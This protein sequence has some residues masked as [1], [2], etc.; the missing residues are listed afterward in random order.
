[1]QPDENDVSTSEIFGYAVYAVP[2][3]ALSS[4]IV[5]LVPPFYSEV[6]G[7]PLAAVGSVFMFLRIMDAV[8]DPAM[9]WLLDRHLFKQAHKPW[10]LAA[11]P[12]AM[13]SGVLL[14]FPPPGL[15]SA[16]Y[17]FGAGFIAYSAYTI[18]LVTHQAW[19]AALARTPRSLS[20]LFGFRELAVIAGVLGTFSLPAIAEAMGYPELETKVHVAGIY[21]VCCFAVCT[22]LSLWMSSDPPSPT[23]RQTS[24]FA[25]ARQILARRD[26]ILLSLAYLASNFGLMSISVLTYFIADQLFD[27]GARYGMAMA[28]HFVIAAAAMALWMNLAA[29]LGD[30]RTMIV[31]T[32]YLGFCLAA[33]PLWR[34]LPDYGYVAMMATLGVGFGAA[35]YLMRSMIGAIANDQEARHGESVRGMAFALATFFDKLGSG[36]AV[37]LVLPLVGYLGFDPNS[38]SSEVGRSAL[39][40]IGV[41]IPLL[42]NFVTISLLLAVGRHTRR[43]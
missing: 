30:R 26:F 10:I 25:S 15:T 19:A 2:L 29:R 20:R 18:G 36:L 31:A 43:H 12:L 8:T 39:Q 7:L 21:I 6:L 5:T 42:A 41:G 27:S 34:A 11:L 28:L 38:A 14:F 33:L 40:N 32:V 1:M 3:T 9:G 37:G 17:L 24:P 13:I 35:P 16:L 22:A 23:R 4:A